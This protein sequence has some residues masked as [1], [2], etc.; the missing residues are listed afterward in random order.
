VLNPERR[1]DLGTVR[2]RHPAG[3][4]RAPS[5]DRGRYSLHRC[6]SLR[7]RRSNRLFFDANVW[8]AELPD[9]RYFL[10]SLVH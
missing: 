9:P 5:G 7:C 3:L 10:V 2:L 4:D 6:R 1:P 8:H